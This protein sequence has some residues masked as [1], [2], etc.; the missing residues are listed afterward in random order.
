MKRLLIILLV[1]ALSTGTALA[2]GGKNHGTTGKG[3]TKTGTTSK[4][5][6]TQ[7]RTGR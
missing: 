2:A 1:V 5:T 4:G 3:E 6:G 7:D